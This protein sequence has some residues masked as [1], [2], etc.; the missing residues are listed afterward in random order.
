MAGFKCFAHSAGPGIETKGDR[1][2]G[3]ASEQERRE[4]TEERREQRE[5][6][7][8]RE[9]ESHDERPREERRPTSEEREEGREKRKNIRIT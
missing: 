8:R 6:R 2:D 5:E 7:R 3:V 4:K 1:E 9:I